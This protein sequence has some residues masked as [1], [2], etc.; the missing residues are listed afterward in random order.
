MFK[1]VKERLFW[2]PVEVAIPQDGGGFEIQTF[3]AQ[4][5]HLPLDEL[6]ATLREVT[7]RGTAAVESVAHLLRDWDEIEDDAAT[8]IPYSLENL[9]MLLQ[10]PGFGPAL[11]EA[12]MRA[13]RPSE[14][15]KRKRGN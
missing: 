8:P 6:E 4:L 2:W 12:I 13:Y 15:E 9:A 14:L 10:Q 3:R 1:V 5:A 11:T 7:L